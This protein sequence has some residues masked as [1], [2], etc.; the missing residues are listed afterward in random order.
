MAYF[1]EFPHTRTYDSD[2][3]WLIK[4]VKDLYDDYSE[5]IEFKDNID[6]WKAGI[7]SDLTA[8]ENSLSA[9][10]TRFNTLALSIDSQF[11]TLE[12]SI[13]NTVNARLAAIDQAVLELTQSIQN[14]MS[15]LV[16][17]LYASINT[18][19][20]LNRAYI[21]TRLQEFLDSLPEYTAENIYI[22]NPVRGYTDTLQ[23][24]IIDLYD[25]ARI[26]ALTASE[27]DALQLTAQ[28]YDD[29]D[30]SAYQYDNLARTI[31]GIG[32]NL[33]RSPFD[34]TFKSVTDLIWQ[35]AGLHQN[36]LTATAYDAKDLT[37]TYYDALDL[38]A[39]DYDWNGQV[40]VV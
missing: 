5:L 40:L 15:E 34:G 1:N 11:A 32:W 10:E 14:Q 21:E 28:D 37:A 26:E 8:V 22:H 17:E 30:L 31:L 12:T 25:L 3:G 39:Y 38:T 36:A 24:T 16:T 19:Q 20:S 7:E 27:Y 6:T 35:L 4:E 18:M 33:I 2:L 29:L 13:N 23:Q 9:F